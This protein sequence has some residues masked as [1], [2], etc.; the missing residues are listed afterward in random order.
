MLNTSCYLSE[1]VS[2]YS[3][4]RLLILGGE[5]RNVRFG[6]IYRLFKFYKYSDTVS[7]FMLFSKLFT[8]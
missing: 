3:C 4:L 6:L 2:P 8:K 1:S 7:R 5:M